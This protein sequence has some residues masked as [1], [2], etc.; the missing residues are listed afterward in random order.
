MFDFRTL[1]FWKIEK[2]K[3]KFLKF[4]MTNKKKAPW[5]G[6]WVSPGLS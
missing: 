4:V 6:L 3:E 1:E 2:F 5:T